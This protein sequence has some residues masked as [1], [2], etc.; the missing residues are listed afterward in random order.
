LTGQLKQALPELERSRTEYNTH[1]SL[2]TYYQQ[3]WDVV[4]AEHKELMV[5]IQK[6]QRCIMILSNAQIVVQ[7][8]NSL[9][10][11]TPENF[12]YL[13]NTTA[14]TLST[15][16]RKF[17]Q[18]DAA[19]AMLTGIP[20]AKHIIGTEETT[21]QETTIPETTIPETTIPETTIQ[22]T[23][24]ETTQDQ[25]PALNLILI[26]RM[27]NANIAVPEKITRLPT[28]VMSISLAQIERIASQSEMLNQMDPMIIQTQ[29]KEDLTV[30]IL[31]MV[32]DIIPKRNLSAFYQQLCMFQNLVWHIRKNPLATKFDQIPIQSNLENASIFANSNS[33]TFVV[34]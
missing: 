31:R 30:P 23:T 24:Q 12:V 29:L 7:L 14:A 20:R 27:R 32:A 4:N 16:I 17:K 2:L 19:F 10:A 6:A 3:T 5:R 13:T 11:M 15:I 22:E 21:T 1:Q 25:Q 34:K 28:N 18:I 33:K 26:N 8:L 9:L